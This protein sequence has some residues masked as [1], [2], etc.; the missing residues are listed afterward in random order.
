MWKAGD[1]ALRICE[2]TP[3]PGDL[4]PQGRLQKGTI[5]LVERVHVDR[6]GTIGLVLCGKPLIDCHDEEVGFLE[7]N[8]RKIVPACD[9]AQN[10]E[11][12]E[13]SELIEI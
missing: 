5:Y 6:K 13:L 1:K 2:H 10:E 7:E 12:L 9:Q 4:L 11:E 8:F 3:R